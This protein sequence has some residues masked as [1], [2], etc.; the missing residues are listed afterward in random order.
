MNKLCLEEVVFD[1]Y[2]RLI[3]VDGETVFNVE[4][5]RYY[6]LSKNTTPLET[7]VTN[8]CCAE[9]GSDS[10][11]VPA[12]C[13]SLNELLQKIQGSGLAGLLAG[14]RFPFIV[15]PACA[16][17]LGTVATDQV[18]VKLKDQFESTFPGLHFRVSMQGSIE[19]PQSINAVTGTGYEKLMEFLESGHLV[20]GW[21][22]P[23]C[24]K[25]YAVSSQIHAKGR[26]ASK[27]SSDSGF[28]V[29]LGGLLDI[30]SAL[31]GTPD[32]L[33][34]ES[35]YPPVL[36]ASGVAH[37]DDRYVFNYKSYG[38]HLEFWGMPRTLV[39]G[40]EQ[41]SEQWNGVVSIFHS[42]DFSVFSEG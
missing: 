19:L 28:E 12:T 13:V 37:E 4:S 14:P 21:I 32:M 11:D 34:N 6:Q 42:V 7:Q 23:E 31:V 18:F 30:G 25:E 29:G 16:G 1:Q 27:V 35:A 40:V 20:I 3:P 8:T 17:D 22:F 9:L 33:V 5:E 10:I 41:V 38:K 24:L 2:G 39:A 15:G 36:C 26:L